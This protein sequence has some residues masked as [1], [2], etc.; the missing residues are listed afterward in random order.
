MLTKLFAALLTVILSMGMIPAQSPPAEPANRAE[1][2]AVNEAK[3]VGVVQPL[4]PA[5]LPEIPV[6]T[7]PVIVEPE[8]AE[9]AVLLTAEEA[10]TVALEQAGLTREQV[11]FSR[12][13]SDWDDGV[14]EWEV[15]FRYENWEY[16]Y[17]I[18]AETGA[19]IHWEREQERSK[20]VVSE[21]PVTEPP[22]KELT[23]EEAKAIVLVHAGLTA[24]QV[25]RLKIEKDRD[26]GIWVY[27][28]EFRSGRMEY[29]YEIH[30]QT[31]KILDWD[32]EI[33]D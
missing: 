9:P 23:A 14:P 7:Q 3:T 21:T 32:K 24:D 5:P 31:G 12:T 33:D 18:H 22:E 15:E 26:D 10:E 29:E 30:A 6:E 16:D 1:T 13:E 25:T 19:V 2:V 28:I 8:R 20:P 27:E 11:K 17:V 4:I